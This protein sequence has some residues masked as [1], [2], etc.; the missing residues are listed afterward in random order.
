MPSETIN[1]IEQIQETLASTTPQI[2]PVVIHSFMV[3]EGYFPD[4]QD[5]HKSRARLGFILS[6]R[7]MMAMAIKHSQ[8]N[9]DQQKEV[10]K[11]YKDRVKEVA[12]RTPDLFDDVDGVMYLRVT[13]EDVET[14]SDLAQR[15]VDTK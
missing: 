14:F 2:P 6:V 15:F 10:Y 8:A 5:W 12:S 9:T 13:P 4:G 11:K 3:G 7:N 1:Y